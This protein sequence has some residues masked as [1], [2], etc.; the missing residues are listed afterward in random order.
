MPINDGGP[1]F[2]R[3][4]WGPSGDFDL[5]IGMSTRTFLSA[6]ALVGIIAYPDDR[7]CPPG[8]DV[9][10]WRAALKAEDARAAVEW[11]D[12]LIAE[13]VKEPNGH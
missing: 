3:S 2:P 5:C 11:A 9:Y 13:L 6:M 7:T 4:S 12:A 8:T 1:A 10:A